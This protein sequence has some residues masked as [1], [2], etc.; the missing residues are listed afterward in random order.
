MVSVK[1][2]HGGSVSTSVSLNQR[3]NRKVRVLSKAVLAVPLSAIVGVFS[4]G[5]QT[6][7]AASESWLGTTDTNWTTH[8]QLVKQHRAWHQQP[9]V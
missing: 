7:N 3:A 9:G 4:S 1:V 8:D 5:P 2:H 6:A